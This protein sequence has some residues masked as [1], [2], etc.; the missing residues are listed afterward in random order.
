MIFGEPEKFAL[1]IEPFL[2]IEEMDDYDCYCGFYIKNKKF[3]SDSSMT[4]NVQRESINNG[5]LKKIVDN[6]KLFHMKIDECFRQLILYRYQN[7]VAE[8]EEEFMEKEWVDIDYDELIYSANL[9]TS[10]LG[11]DRY[12]IFCVGFLD[13]VRL[14]SYKSS[15]NFFSLGELHQ[16][17]INECVL[18]KIDLKNILNEIN[19]VVLKVI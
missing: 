5:A 16:Y 19:N 12:H 6:E 1:I 2:F 3:V 4:F 8:S 11:T 14:I 15:I 9:E 7:W 18:S 10:S 13:K 17:N